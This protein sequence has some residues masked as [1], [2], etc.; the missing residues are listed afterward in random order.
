[1]KFSLNKKDI[2]EILQHLQIIPPQKSNVVAVSNLKLDVDAE[3]NSIKLT[4]TDFNI[5]AIVTIPSNVIESGTILVNAKQFSDIVN[6]LPLA[7]INFSL[8]DDHLFIECEKAK[9]TISYIESKYFPEDAFIDSETALVINAKNFKKMIN[10][11]S[12]CV[13]TES[14]QPALTGIY[15]KFSKSSLTVTATDSKRVSETILN[16]NFDIET[17]HEVVLPTKALSFVEKN[18]TDSINEVIFK[19]DSKRISFHFGNM[20]L[21]SNKFESKY[22]NYTPAFKV[23]PTNFLTIDKASLKDAL[24]RVSLFSDDSD[25]LVRIS[26]NDS[27]LIIESLISEKGNAKES[28]SDFAYSGP[29]VSF[30]INVKFLLSFVQVIETDEVII[31]FKSV[32]EPFYILNNKEFENLNV[33]FV[34]M[35]MRI[36]RR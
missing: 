28:L 23:I 10:F 24:R 26:L 22:P 16:T 8:R 7:S 31:Q 34:L 13:A 25:N 33:R 18:I 3:T 1:M 32:E 36:E 20:I 11:T 17:D 21:I 15:L 14:P 5:T 4:A 12:F 2:S 30:G 9:F 27:L 6:S 35:P 29:E 19:Y